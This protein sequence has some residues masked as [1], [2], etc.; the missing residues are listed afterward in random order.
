MA[1]N[2]TKI[3]KA[4]KEKTLDLKT[5][6]KS[7]NVEYRGLFN[8]WPFSNIG[9]SYLTCA[10]LYSVNTSALLEKSLDQQALDFFSSLENLPRVDNTDYDG[11]IQNGVFAL[12]YLIERN[13][14][15]CLVLTK[16]DQVLAKLLNSKNMTL[17]TLEWSDFSIVWSPDVP[18]SHVYSMKVPGRDVVAYG[19]EIARCLQKKKSRFFLSLITMVSVKNSY[20]AN[21]L[22]YDRVTGYL[23]RFEPFQVQFKQFHTKKFDQQLV[24]LFRTLD[25][26]NFRGM[27]HAP[28]LSYLR[29]LQLKAEEE[30]EQTSSDPAGFCLPWSILYADTRLSL[31]NQDPESIPQLFQ[32]M[33]KKHKI[34]LTRFI[35]NYADNLS[36]INWKVYIDFLEKYPK[37][38][39]FTDSRIPMYAL[40]L[41][42]LSEYASFYAY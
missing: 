34:S 33:A 23:E 25:P 1:C 10:R 19:D 29:G 17:E 6:A 24:R 16:F 36:E 2:E 8:F 9:S 3:I 32:I 14:S 42:K 13:R 39:K 40:F 26:L 38:R 5:V 4:C 12:I 37:Y 41:K 31:P 35:R 20:H 18:N 27:I 28:D 21:I 7:C 11:Y 30:E 22:F 15:E